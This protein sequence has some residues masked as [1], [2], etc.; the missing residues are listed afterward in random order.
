MKFPTP[1]PLKV[2]PLTPAL[3]DQIALKRPDRAMLI[4]G[5]SIGFWIIAMLLVAS[6]VVVLL[7][8]LF[9]GASFPSLLS[10][11]IYCVA[12]YSGVSFGWRAGSAIIIAA[13]RRPPDV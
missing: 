2:K 8:Y 10:G 3:A 1:P 13:M 7:G 12:V 4:I 11:L 9:G 5:I 6:L